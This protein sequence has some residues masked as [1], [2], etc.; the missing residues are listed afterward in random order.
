MASKQSEELKTLYRSWIVAFS[1][2][3]E[4]GLD[5]SRALAAAAR[6]AGVDVTLEEEPEMQHVY[7]FLAGVAPEADAAIGRLA[8]WVRPKLGLD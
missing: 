1:A 6:K 4:M 3:P 7:H 5:D 2:N 8:K